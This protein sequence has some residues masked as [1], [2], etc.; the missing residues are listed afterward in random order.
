MA[1]TSSPTP[2]VKMR[3]LA[4][5][6]AKVFLRIFSTSVSPMVGWPSVKK[7]TLNDRPSSFVRYSRAVGRASLIAVPPVASRCFDPFARLPQLFSELASSS[8][9]RYLLTEV[10]KLMRAKRSFGP[11]F[12]SRVLEGVAGLLHLDAAHRPRRV[13]H[14]H[15]V[16]RH[17]GFLRHLHFRRD[18]QREEAGF[19][20]DGPMRQGGQADVLVAGRVEELEVLVELGLVLVELH[21]DL[22]VVDA[23]QAKWRASGCRRW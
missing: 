4:V 8:L 6:L 14:E 3:V 20:R 13:Q 21:V 1:L 18:E 19:R 10:A 17:L 23:L 5:F 22:V 9:S 7:T 2:K 16:A 15:H 11:R 12:L